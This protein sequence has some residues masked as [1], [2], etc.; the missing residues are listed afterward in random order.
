[1]GSVK[2]V[3]YWFGV[4]L[5]AHGCTCANCKVCCVFFS[6][7]L[8]SMPTVSVVPWFSLPNIARSAPYF[9][10]NSAHCPNNG[11]SAHGLFLLWQVS[12]LSPLWCVYDRF[13]YGNNH[14][15]PRVYTKL[16]EFSARGRHIFFVFGSNGHHHLVFIRARQLEVLSWPVPHKWTYVY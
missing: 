3:I 13:M 6:G 7:K 8:S 1:V 11:R 9:S 16:I 4:F 10:S 12:C 2:S 14:Y 5:N 15:F